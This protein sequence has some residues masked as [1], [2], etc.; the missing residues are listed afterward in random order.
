MDK[1]YHV[2]GTR[3]CLVLFVTGSLLVCMQLYLTIVI[4]IKL[5]L[6]T[7]GFLRHCFNRNRTK[8]NKIVLEWQFLGADI[9]VILYAFI[10]LNTSTHLYI[11]AVLYDHEG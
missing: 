9:I 6:L 11:R 1:L 3:N 8:W 5:V 2:L 7:F 10:K 4:L